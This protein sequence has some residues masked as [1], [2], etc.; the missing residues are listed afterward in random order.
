MTLEDS[1]ARFARVLHRRCLRPFLRYG[2][3]NA[4]ND[5]RSIGK[6]S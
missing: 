3:V 2:V 1:F 5:N 6:V 4:A